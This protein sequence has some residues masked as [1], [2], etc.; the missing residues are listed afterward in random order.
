M[1]NHP[2]RSKA[3][4]P[5]EHLQTAGKLYPGA[6]KQLD[7]FRAG[8]GRDGLPDWPEWCFV[9]LAASYAVVSGGGDYRL[10]LDLIGDVGRLAALAAWRVTQGG[11]RFDPAIYNAVIKTPITGDLPREILYRMP[12]WCVYIETPDAEIYGG[13][14]YGFFAHMEWDANTGR[15]ELR[16][17]VDSEESL[18]PVPIH[19]GDW[20]LREAVDRAMDSK[21]QAAANP[22]ID[23]MFGSLPT[24]GVAKQATAEIEPLVSLLIYLCTA[25]AELGAGE[26][27]PQK[28][29]PKRTKRGW[30]LFPPDKPNTWDVGVRLG[31]AL[32]RAY[33]Q[34]ETDPNGTHAGPRPHI[35]RAHWHS[36]WTGPRDGERKLTVKWLPPISVNLDDPDD[37]PTTL[38]PI[39]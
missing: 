11:Y 30:R 33:H 20:S 19:M 28:P 34:A 14:M 29:K 21:I 39:K 10:D 17:L 12:E 15:E 36:F 9:P 6:W 38:R 35:R 25:N 5:R 1:T 31:A 27:R 3:C 4:R 7:Q 2:N 37:L 24:V 8:R 23:K 13:R 18:M 32:R 22:S 16:L 26:H